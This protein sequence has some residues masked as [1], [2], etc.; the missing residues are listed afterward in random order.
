MYQH[1][2]YDSLTVGPAV[3]GWRFHCPE[4]QTAGSLPHP[5]VH[6]LQA[7]HSL[8][9]ALGMLQDRY[10]VSARGTHILLDDVHYK[11][12]ITAMVQYINIDFN[13]SFTDMQ[14]YIVKKQES[15]RSLKNSH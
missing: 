4:P 10:Q 8:V 9:G 5:A 1:K 12:K 15:S 14:L 2:G 6:Q 7:C 13:E 11:E 3:E